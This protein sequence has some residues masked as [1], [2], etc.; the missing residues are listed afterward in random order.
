MSSRLNHVDRTGLA[1]YALVAA[2]MLIILVSVSPTSSAGN[3]AQPE[4][5]TCSYDA[6]GSLVCETLDG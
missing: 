1:I 5:T 6:G 2:V 3:L 4:A